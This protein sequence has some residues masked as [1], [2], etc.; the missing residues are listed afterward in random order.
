MLVKSSLKVA[1]PD[2]EL[3]NVSTAKVKRTPVV[4]CPG[5]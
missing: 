4:T 2:V 1:F 5:I 3:R